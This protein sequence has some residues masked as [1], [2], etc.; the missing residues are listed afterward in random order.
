MPQIDIRPV[1][2]AD[3]AA[4]LPLWQAY[5]QFY[6]SELPAATTANTWQR[7]LDP[8]EPTHAALAW[9]DGRAV[10]L[11]QWIFHRSN[12]SVANSCY[13]QDLFVSPQVR[14]GGIGRRLIEHVYTHARSAGGPRVHWLTQESNHT[15]MQLYDRIAER[16]GFTQYSHSL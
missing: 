8:A 16:A 14:G 10:G 12:W 1:A 9:R 15:A 6:E 5:L 4:W 2:P 3:Q 11:A 7:F 13:L